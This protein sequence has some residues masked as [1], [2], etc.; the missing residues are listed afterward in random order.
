MSQAVCRRCSQ[1]LS[2]CTRTRGRG[3][4]GCV[5]QGGES[6]MHAGGRQTL[7]C[8]VLSGRVGGQG[9]APGGVRRVGQE[10]LVAV[11]VCFLLQL[12]FL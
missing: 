2:L 5:G 1:L 10:A 3:G 11:L 8:R 9:G 7:T 12:P 6:G 4:G